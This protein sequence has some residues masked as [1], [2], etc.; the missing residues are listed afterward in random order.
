M[1][2]QNAPHF[3]MLNICCCFLL[4]IFVTKHYIPFMNLYL[5]YN[6]IAGAK[7]IEEKYFRHGNFGM[8]EG[9]MSLW[10]Q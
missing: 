4:Y 3:K 2:F 1:A 6:I 5:H 8:M 9:Y 7:Q 10:I